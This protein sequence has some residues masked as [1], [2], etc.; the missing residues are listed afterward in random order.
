MHYLFIH[1]LK[2]H[3][4]ALRSLSFYCHTVNLVPSGSPWIWG[5]GV[6]DWFALV[7]TLPCIVRIIIF[8]YRIIWSSF[9]YN[10][11]FRMFSVHR[12]SQLYVNIFMPALPVSSVSTKTQYPRPFLVLFTHIH[13]PVCRLLSCTSCREGICRTRY[14]AHLQKHNDCWRTGIKVNTESVLCLIWQG[15]IWPQVI[16]GVIGNVLNVAVNCILL[17]VL[18]LGIV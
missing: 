14:S 18:D 6:V 10:T 2:L 5:T 9:T 4:R 3:S 16:T 13:C 11:H 1:F 12:L 17:Y 7:V 15:I 8:F